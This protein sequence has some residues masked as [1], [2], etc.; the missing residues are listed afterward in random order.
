MTD[1]CTLHDTSGVR[2]M[3]PESTV[4]K[5]SRCD[6]IKESAD[7]FCRLSWFRLLRTKDMNNIIENVGSLK[8]SS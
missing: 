4:F 7:Q 8:Q 3:V 1:V 6:V 2:C 5:H